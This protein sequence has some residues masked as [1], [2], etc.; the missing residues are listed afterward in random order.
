MMGMVEGVW[1]HMTGYLRAA[2]IAVFH[3]LFPAKALERATRRTS[4]REIEMRLL[5][6]L[7]DPAREAIDVG[8][9]IGLY[10][11]A[12]VPLASRVIAIEPHPRLAGVL[13]SL[14]ADRVEVREAIVTRDGGGQHELEVD[15]VDHREADALGHIADGPQREGTRRFAV[16][17]L[18][19]DDFADRPVGF[20][21]I[22]VEGHEL[23]ALEGAT[24]LIEKQRP[25]FLVE[26]EARH[27]AAA[28]GDI[29]AY[30]AERDY[31]GFFARAGQMNPVS[32][33]SSSLQEERNL[34]G[35]GTREAADYVNNFVF[36]PAEANWRATV[37]R[38]D[39][40]LA[41]AGR[42]T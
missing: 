42:S 8:A 16:P 11:A 30:F 6:A 23:A 25:I 28:P 34:E 21:K 12:L 35:Y 18:C 2:R 31:V 17:T 4:E 39:A 37:A 22:D 1:R 14:P 38:C 7:C 5:P 24:A 9:N 40:I 26:A 33:F 10:A 27:R 36:L 13:R 20:V 32:E 3:R 41:E 15:L 29:F 19:L